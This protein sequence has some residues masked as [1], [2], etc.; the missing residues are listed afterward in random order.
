RAYEL[1]VSNKEFVLTCKEAKLRVLLDFMRKRQET[2]LTAKAAE[3][4]RKLDRAKKAGDAAVEKAQSDLDAAV[5]AAAV[6]KQALDRIQDQLSKCVIRA[7]ADGILVYAKE[8]FWDPNSQ[9]RP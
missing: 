6:E 3:A 7:S 4:A 8:R 5:A 9:I 2:E 1:N